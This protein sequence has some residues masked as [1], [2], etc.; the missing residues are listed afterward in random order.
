MELRSHIETVT[1]T[2]VATWS[3]GF[4]TNPT[5]TWTFRRIGRLVMLVAGGTLSATSNNTTFL[6]GAN[7]VPVHLRPTFTSVNNVW[8]VTDNGVTQLGVMT[9]SN[10]GQLSYLA[11]VANGVFTNSGTK[12]FIG[13][14]VFSYLLD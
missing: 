3:T 2:F 1:G 7:D 8:R 14:Q 5:T 11:T 4:T 12:G 6:S 10:A 9:M 13:R